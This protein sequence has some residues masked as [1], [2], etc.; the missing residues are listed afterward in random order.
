[1]PGSQPQRS[2][3]VGFANGVARPLDRSAERL[4]H[5]YNVTLG[6]LL[7]QSHGG[8]VPAFQNLVNDWA[9]RHGRVPSEPA[10]TLGELIGVLLTRGGGAERFLP[11]A[12]AH[13]PHAN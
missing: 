3:L 6:E 13:D 10:T 5:L 8:E 2:A 4:Q 7:G 11:W 1:M 12:P 9:A